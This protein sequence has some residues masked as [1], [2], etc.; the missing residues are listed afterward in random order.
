MKPVNIVACRILIS[1]NLLC[2]QTALAADV[3]RCGNSYQDTPCKAVASK[4]IN[5]KP[6]AASTSNVTTKKIELPTAVNADCKQ[7]GEAAKSIAKMRESGLE[8]GALK[9]S[10]TDSYTAALV[11]D[12]FKHQ[13]SAFQIQ[14]AIERECVQQQQKTSLTGKWMAEARRLLGFGAAS[15][16]ANI[17]AKPP[18]PA[19]PAPTKPTL[20]KPAPATPVSPQI[21]STAEP[22]PVAEPTPPPAPIVQPEQAAPAAPTPAPAPTVETAPPEPTPPAQPVAKKPVAKAAQDDNQGMCD[23][24]KAGLKNISE[25]K[26][27]GGDDAL[28]QDLKQQED[29]LKSVM[30]SAGC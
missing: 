2:A 5:Q 30:D 7:R 25:Q 13:G 1:A 3:Y 20:T 8:E 6:A 16:S 15:N 18:A 26:H 23:S 10:A 24:L 14:N 21:K 4:P 22:K 9:S 17:S 28:M 19:K 11:T 12:V 27:K 29:N